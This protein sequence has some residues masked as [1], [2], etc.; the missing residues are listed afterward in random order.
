LDYNPKEIRIFSRG[1][2]AQVEMKKQYPNCHYIIGDIRDSSALN[3]A[4]NNVDYIFHEAAIKHVP[5]C[6]N[7]PN[8]AIKTNVLGV[9]NLITAAC[10]N[11]VER[12]VNMSTDKAVY[13]NSLYGL[14]KAIGEKMFIQANDLPYSTEFM[15]IRSG[16]VFGSSGSVIPLLIDQVKRHDS[17]ILTDSNM[18]RY[19]TSVMNV[20]HLLICVMIS[21]NRGKTYITSEPVSFSLG[22]I[23]SVIN[24]LYGS[25]KTIIQENGARPGEKIHEHLFSDVETVYSMSKLGLERVINN[26]KQSSYDCLASDQI[27]LIKEMIVEI[28]NHE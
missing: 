27:S 28:Q 25:S 11:G 5:I 22:A 7:Q 18:T 23:A 4:C 9:S 26:C 16:N 19:F 1:E 24:T 10:L 12:V 14:T 15:N 13:P 2:I 20:V 17:I 3:L 21:G 8:E 6:E